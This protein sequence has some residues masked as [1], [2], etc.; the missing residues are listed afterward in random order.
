MA[1][2]YE[3]ALLDALVIFSSLFATLYL[4]MKWKHTYWQRHGVSTLPTHWFFGHFKDAMLFRKS[5]GVVLSELHKQAE[6]EDVL[7]I[8]I[9]H[10]PF[11]I[12]RNPELIKQIMIKDFNIFPNHYFRGANNSDTISKWSLFSIRYPEWK[13]LR[14][15][16]TPV[17]TSGKLK[18]LFQL[19]QES[20]E[21][22][23][24]HLHDQIKDNSK[25][26]SIKVKDTFYKYTTDVTSSVA[27]GIRTNCFDTPSPEFYVNSRKAFVQTILSTLQL[28]F[29]FFLPSIGKYLG[30]SML[31]RYTDY[32]RKVFWDSMDNRSVTKI[33]RGDL[34]DSLLQLKTETPDNMN[35]RF[36]GDAL[37]A[38]A[39]IFFV[40]GRETSI[41]T[42]TCAL[43]ELAKQPE[44]QRRVREEILKTIQDANDV[45]Y[46]A[47]HNMKYLHQVINET[48]RLYPPAPIID[49]FPLSDYTFPGTKITV[50]KNIPV[51]VVL[52]G[53]QSD[54][55]YYL[56]PMRFDPERFSDERKDEIVPSTFLPF[57]EG[58]RNCIG[59]RL[60]I[61]QT[62]VGLIAILRDY[63][64]TLHPSW[65]DPIDPR[66]VFISPPAEF[67][68]NFKRI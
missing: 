33:K 35:V 11:L 58:P 28:F 13:Y 8:Y 51:Y 5:A 37:L 10:K 60:G 19:M 34:I 9:L 67:L 26:M 49:R 15:K 22:M 24:D 4:W 68:L 47:V 18:N 16:M 50:K 12:L 61:L 53:I 62:T 31:G 32:F 29:L 41:A 48:L 20:G 66:N 40:A 36:E 21:K 38:Q 17:F 2:L 25:I 64:V 3:C 52:R 14:S 54:P 30:G 55:R 44:I 6:N 23:R 56:D 57:G 42:M 7:G 43:F 65:K 46:E 63:E 59:M 1:I 39:A 27:F 45:T